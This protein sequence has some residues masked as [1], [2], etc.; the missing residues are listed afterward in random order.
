[1][2]VFFE[3][4]YFLPDSS[5]SSYDSYVFSAEFLIADVPPPVESLLFLN[6]SYWNFIV[7]V[8]TTGETKCFH[9]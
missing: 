4:G 7:N 9:K 6:N 3:G 2:I 1:M 8:F 5:L